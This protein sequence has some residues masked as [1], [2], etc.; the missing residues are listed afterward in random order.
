MSYQVWTSQT[1]WYCWDTDEVQHVPWLPGIYRVV[2]DTWDPRGLLNGRQDVLQHEIPVC[3][4]AGAP[5]GSNLMWVDTAR[6]G[7]ARAWTWPAGCHQGVRSRRTFWTVC[8]KHGPSME[9]ENVLACVGG[10]QRTRWPGKGPRFQLPSPL[11][12]IPSQLALLL[13]PLKATLLQRDSGFSCSPFSSILAERKV[14]PACVDHARAV[15]PVIHWNEEAKCHLVRGADPKWGGS[16]KSLAWFQVCF[17]CLHVHM[18]ALGCC[19]SR[20]PKV[21]ISWM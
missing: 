20:L 15:L 9:A 16:P 21:S 4:A 3:R 18:G 12:A 8:G 17:L 11:Q 19:I 10:V 14:L 13:H 6:Q 7:K 2:G 5:R 1:L